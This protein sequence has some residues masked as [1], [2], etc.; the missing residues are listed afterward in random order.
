MNKYVWDV[1]FVLFWFF[2]VWLVSWFFFKEYKKMSLLQSSM[3]LT[4]K[5]SGILLIL[6]NKK[7]LK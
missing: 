3:S 4:C 2:F 6:K 5:I 1:F 7:H